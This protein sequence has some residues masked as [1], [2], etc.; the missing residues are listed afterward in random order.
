MNPLVGTKVIVDL[1]C[2]PVASDVFAHDRSVCEQ[3]QESQFS[4][5][6]EHNAVSYYFIQPTPCMYVVDMP[7]VGQCQP[8]VDVR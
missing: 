1:P 5:S 7:A 3:P 4:N 2:L 8:D 6:T